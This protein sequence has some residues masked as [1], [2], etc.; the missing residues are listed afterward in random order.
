MIELVALFFFSKKI[1]E[2]CNEKN[3]KAGK[4][5]ALL[6]VSWFG[7]EITVFLIGFSF[8]DPSESTIYKLILPALIAAVGLA[9]LVLQKVKSLDS[10]KNLELDEFA[11]ISN[12]E[13][14]K[15]FR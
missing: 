14:F 9:Y 4:W 7:A 12:D 6:F 15:H 1:R 5:V 2:T 8:L 13:K 10:N 3:L 11:T